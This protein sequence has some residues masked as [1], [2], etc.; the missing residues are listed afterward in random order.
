MILK[1]L[2][3]TR[4]IPVDCTI[5]MTNGIPAHTPMPRPR[6]PVISFCFVFFFRPHPDLVNIPE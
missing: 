1:N 4:T 6:E 2:T 5:R 3:D